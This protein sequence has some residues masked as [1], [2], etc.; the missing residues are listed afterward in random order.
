MLQQAPPYQIESITGENKLAYHRQ[1]IEDIRQREYSIKN[2]DASKGLELSTNSSNR[3]SRALELL[4]MT[5]SSN[6]VSFV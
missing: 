6:G 5:I 3:L 2:A 4:H 1:I